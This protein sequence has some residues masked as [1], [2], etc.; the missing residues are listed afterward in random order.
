MVTILD[1]ILTQKHS[2]LVAEHSR[3]SI[4]EFSGHFALLA[5]WP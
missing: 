2:N 4:D 1:S 3:R 5:T